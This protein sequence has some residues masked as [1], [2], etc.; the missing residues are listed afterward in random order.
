MQSISGGIF[1]P[2]LF[3]QHILSSTI[4]PFYNCLTCRNIRYTCNVLNI[5]I[6]KKCF[7]FL[8]TYAG[9]LFVIV[10]AEMPMMAITSNTCVITQSAFSELKAVAY[11]KSE[12]VSMAVCTYFNFPNSVKWN[13]SICQISFLWLSFALLP[14]GNNIDYRKGM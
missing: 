12:Y 5:V 2:F 1:H 13:T 8:D 9:P 11:W 6:G 3:V 14:S 10:Y 4:W 7:N